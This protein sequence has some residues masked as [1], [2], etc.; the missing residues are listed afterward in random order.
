MYGQNYAKKCKNPCSK[1]HFP[2]NSRKW[3]KIPRHYQDFIHFPRRGLSRTFQDIPGQYPLCI[4]TEI[5]LLKVVVVIVFYYP[6]VHCS[7]K[8]GLVEVVIL[9]DVLGSSSVLKSYVC[10][11]INEGNQ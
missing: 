8:Q 6:S 7:T 1:G 2:G 5:I 3:L 9:G 11:Q 10:S 4:M